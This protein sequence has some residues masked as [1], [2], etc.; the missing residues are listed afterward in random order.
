MTAFAVCAKSGSFKRPEGVTSIPLYSQASKRVACPAGTTVV[1]G[2][3]F[4]FTP[5]DDTQTFLAS[6]E[7]FDGPDA[8]SRRDDGWLASATNE[9]D[10]DAPMF[11]YAICAA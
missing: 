11:V 7:P 3:A 9:T 5:P 4:I 8:D 10:T 6:T 2:G 1:G